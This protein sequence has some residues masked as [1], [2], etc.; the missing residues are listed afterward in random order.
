MVPFG[1]D[2]ILFL[3]LASTSWHILV[4]GTTEV[5][6]KDNIVFSPMAETLAFVS[7]NKSLDELTPADYANSVR[8][9]LKN[10]ITYKY[11]QA[12]TMMAYLLEPKIEDM[13]QQ[14][15]GEGFGEAEKESIKQAII[16][17]IKN[18][19]KQASQ[20]PVI[21]TTLLE[22]RNELRQII[23]NDLPHIAVLNFQELAP[24]ANI[25]MIKRISWEP[26]TLSV[27]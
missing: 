13:L 19:S 22:K 5:N 21:L 10:Y 2:D 4:R 17:E 23:K 26:E 15:S 1:E 18:D 24:T 20:Q 25:Q 14:E 11:S 12:G 27:K 8:I 3:I 16:Y 6:L 7:G 9:A